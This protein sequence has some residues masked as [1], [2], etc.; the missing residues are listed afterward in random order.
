VVEAHHPLQ[1]LDGCPVS[2]RQHA[3]AAFSM[4]YRHLV[5]LLQRCALVSGSGRVGEPVAPYF[6]RLARS[7]MWAWSLDLEAVSSS[8]M[9]FLAESGIM[10]LLQSMFG[11]RQSVQAA[12]ALQ[13]R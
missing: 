3:R 4:L 7:I 1:N 10:P 6:A 13:T 5:Q 11:V 12:A 2:V 8:D 9:T